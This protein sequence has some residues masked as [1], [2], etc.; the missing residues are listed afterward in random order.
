MDTCAAAVFTF[1][2]GGSENPPPSCMGPPQGAPFLLVALNG[3]SRPCRSC[4]MAPLFEIHVSYLL[5]RL[6]TWARR[7]L[8][9]ADRTPKPRAKPTIRHT[10]LG[11]IFLLNLGR[12]RSPVPSSP[13]LPPRNRPMAEFGV[14]KMTSPVK[15]LVRCIST[16][17]PHA[18]P[19]ALKPSSPIQKKGPGDGGSTRPLT[20]TFFKGTLGDAVSMIFGPAFPPPHLKKT[21]DCKIFVPVLKKQHR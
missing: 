15:I 17:Y 5:I 7:Y 6:R 9:R 1:V 21:N 11:S 8:E 10:R 12:F 19:F 3:G 14:L 13:Y 20:T 4:A 18:V 16:Q 2:D